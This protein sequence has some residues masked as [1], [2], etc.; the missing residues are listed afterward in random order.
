MKKPQEKR[1]ALKV[2]E[3][4]IESERGLSGLAVGKGRNKSAPYRVTFQ[5]LEA[6]KLDMKE[7]FEW[8]GLCLGLEVKNIPQA[9]HGVF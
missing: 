5:E 7:A 1:K 8:T 4:L 2:T 6:G 9:L 3:H